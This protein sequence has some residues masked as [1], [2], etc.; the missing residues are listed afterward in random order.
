MFDTATLTIFYD[1]TRGEPRGHRSRTADAANA[2][3]GSCI[4]CGLCVQVCPTGIDIRKGTQIECIGCA[5]C[6][7]VCDRVMDDMQYPRGLIRYTTEDALAGKPVRVLRPRVVAYGAMLAAMSLLFVWAL[8][9]RVPFAVD[10]LRDRARLYRLTEEGDIENVYTL[11]I[12]NK[13]QAPHVYRVTVAPAPFALSGPGSIEVAAG[14]IA[15][16]PVRVR[17]ASEPAPPSSSPVTF[18]IARV[19]DPGRVVE[20]ASRFLAPRRAAGARP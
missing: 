14:A 20:E 19:D 9:H 6:I 3:L 2:W 18:A 13:D 5:A 16:V 10:V 17:V 8:V 12:M 15:D 7:D 11:K 1:R 4:D